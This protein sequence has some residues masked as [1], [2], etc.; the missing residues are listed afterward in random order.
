M[1]LVVGRPG[2]TNVYLAFADTTDLNRSKIIA[3]AYI[4]A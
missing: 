1:F 4:D 3:A 2:G